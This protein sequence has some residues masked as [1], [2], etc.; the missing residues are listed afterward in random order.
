[1]TDFASLFDNFE[2]SA[3]RFE[4]LPVYDVPE[5]IDA[6]AAFE[7][8]ETVPADWAEEWLDYVREMITGGKSMRRVRVIPNPITT[9][10]RFES[11]MY[12]SSVQAGEAVL[13][14]PAS[15]LPVIAR[16]TPDFW[17]FD[18]KVVGVM[19]YDDKGAFLGGDVVDDSSEVG[20]FVEISKALLKVAVP[21][22]PEG[23][24]AK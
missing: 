7:N 8:E 20:R 3:F 4:S 13:T 10:Y 11:L 6:L 19:R 18:N 12:P 15:Q 5:E 24:G 16:N 22:E 17:L 2:S 9:Y 23:G 14:V 21:I 1:M